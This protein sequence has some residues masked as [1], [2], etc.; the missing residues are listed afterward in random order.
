MR[1]LC[2][3]PARA[4]SKRLP[5]KNTVALA[6]RPLLAYTI[7]AALQSGIFDRVCVSTESEEIAEA[8]ERSGAEIP[9]R[10]P[11]ELS[12]DTV[13]NVAVS[14]HLRDHLAA[15]GA[16]YE[17]VYVLQPSSPLRSAAH[18]RDAWAV[19]SSGDFDFLVSTTVIDPHYFHWALT[20]DGAGARMFFGKRFMRIRQELPAVYRP[21]GAIKI[22]RVAALRAQGDFFGERLGVYE[23]P[24]EA[25]VHVAIRADLVAC[26]AYLE[27]RRSCSGLT[28]RS[29]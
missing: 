22:A 1:P 20:R 27:E 18:V 10:R 9:Y 6:G 19:F 13:T 4:G 24:E 16:A 25:S 12:G 29:R 26:E 2:V 17:I 21:N 28:A 8:A 11:A 23:M 7:E 15:L 14:L 3:I 5:G